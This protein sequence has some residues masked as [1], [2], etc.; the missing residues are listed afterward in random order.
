M[1][2]AAAA[3]AVIAIAYSVFVVAL[4]RARDR[5]ISRFVV[6]GG[7]GVDAREVPSNLTVRKDLGGYDGMTFYRLALNPFTH[8]EKAYG[9]ELDNPS[10]RQQRI[11]YPLL[12][13]ITTL[14]NARLVP[15]AL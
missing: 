14:G 7:P 15:S 3:A 6:A 12:V 4:W 5:D 2:S 13:F 8:E 11:G 1:K 9:I 10:Y